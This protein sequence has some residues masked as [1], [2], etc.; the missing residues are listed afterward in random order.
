MPQ[1][2]FFLLSR[3]ER[4]TG[5]GRFTTGISSQENLEN[6][7]L[8]LQKVLNPTEST[9]NSLE[10]R[11]QDNLDKTE[12]RNGEKVK[13]NLFFFFYYDSGSLW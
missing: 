6:I 5:Q 8:F 9:T 13:D 1:S 12:F 7:R 11:E 4:E 10:E 3:K 2:T